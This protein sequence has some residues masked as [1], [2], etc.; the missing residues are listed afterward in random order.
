M[1]V[2]EDLEEY[3]YSDNEYA[4]EYSYPDDEYSEDYSFLV[5]ED[6]YEEFSRNEQCIAAPIVFFVRSIITIIVYNIILGRDVWYTGKSL[7]N[8]NHF[9]VRNSS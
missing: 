2:T 6:S 7:G 4:E 3:S 1:N 5:D 9:E 8:Y